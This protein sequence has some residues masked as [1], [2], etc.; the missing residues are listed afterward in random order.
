MYDKDSDKTYTGTSNAILAQWMIDILLSY[1]CKVNSKIC[2]AILY[3]SS[4]IT[5]HLSEISSLNTHRD[6]S[7][8]SPVSP[9]YIAAKHSQSKRV[10]DVFLVQEN[11]T[12]VLP[13]IGYSVE[14]VRPKS[15]EFH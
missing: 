10:S 9:V 12:M 1:F 4:E 7:I 6:N 2:C 3:S 11:Q 15:R 13:L 8:N 5:S 14:R